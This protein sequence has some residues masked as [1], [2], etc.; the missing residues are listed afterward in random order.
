MVGPSKND[1]PFW[2]PDKDRKGRSIPRSLLD[3]AQLVWSRVVYLTERE[4]KDTARAAEILETAVGVVSRLMQRRGPN[5]RILDPESYLYWAEARIVYRIVEREK[6]VQFIYD[7]EPVLQAKAGNY[8]N[9]MSGT[10]TQLLIR[11]IMR[12]MD[13]RTRRMFLLRVKGF[14]WEQVGAFVGMKANHAAVA[15]NA[16]V[17]RTRQRILRCR[18]G[19]T[20]PAAG[21]VR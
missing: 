4:L 20:K 19:K 15:Y 2:M 18:P 5:H 8:R 7:L 12:Y 13:A 14:S 11:Q 17:E 9:R 3:L 6:M 21:G 1:P 10:Q 16:G